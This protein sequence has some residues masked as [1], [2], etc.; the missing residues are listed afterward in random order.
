MM[1]GY[2]LMKAARSQPGF[3]ARDS[4]RLKAAIM[5]FWKVN[6]PGRNFSTRRKLFSR[7]NISPG[8]G[9]SNIR[10]G[11]K[12]TCRLALSRS[13]LLPKADM[14]GATR[15]VRFGPKADT[16]AL[17]NLGGKIIVISANFTPE[18]G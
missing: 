11:Q 8:R 7:R 18:S 4:S 10:F 3:R 17:Q 15:Y 5:R 1:R 13:A 12:H 9:W 6:Q 2:H 14:C 16:R